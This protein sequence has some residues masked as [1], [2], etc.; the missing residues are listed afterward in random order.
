MIRD[1]FT[2][3]FL[4]SVIGLKNSCH[5]F[6]QSDAKLTPITTWS[7]VISRALGSLVGS[8]VLE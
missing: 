1:C 3:A 2:F 5:S 4:R 6:D 8:T 7:P